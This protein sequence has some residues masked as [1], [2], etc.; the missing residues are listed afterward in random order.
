MFSML[1]LLVSSCLSVPLA[2]CFSLLCFSLLYSLPFLLICLCLLVF[3]RLWLLAFS[4]IY[5]FAF[6][7]IGCCLSLDAFHCHWLLAL[8]VFLSFCFLLFSYRLLLPSASCL[9]LFA[10]HCCCLNF[11]HHFPSFLPHIS[12]VPMV[13]LYF[14]YLLEV[15]YQSWKAGKK[16]RSEGQKQENEWNKCKKT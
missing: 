7:L 5:V 6:L 4:L 1:F 2:S 15:V 14:R 13:A 10:F 8:C 12:F 16:A 3:H 11:L 9:L